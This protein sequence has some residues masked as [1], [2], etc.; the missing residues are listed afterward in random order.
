MG[1]VGRRRRAAAAAGSALL[2]VAACSAPADDPAGHGS[3]TTTSATTAPPSTTPTTTPTGESATRTSAIPPPSP[4]TTTSSTATADALGGYGVSAGHPAAVAVGMGVLERGGNA[5]DAAV[6]VAFAVSVAEPFG[7]GLGGGGAAVLV[8]P[9]VPAEAYTYRETVALDGEIPASGTGIPGY[10]AGLAQL[11]A[12]HGSLDWAVLVEPAVVLAEDG[13]PV[14]E[15][16]ADELRTPA[17]RAAVADVAA[18]HHDDGS[19][20]RAGDPLRQP[21]LA[22]T[23]RILAAD[24]PQAFYG[25]ALT[26]D[27][28]EVDGLDRESLAAYRVQVGPPVRG[29]VGPVDL[30]TA[31]PPLVGATLVQQLQVAEAAGISDLAPGSA[32]SVDLL[33]RAWRVADES[34]GTVL[35]DPGFVDVPVAELTD[36][37]A[38][39]VLAAELADGSGPLAVAMA[40]PVR[41]GTTTQVSVV[42]AD[43]LAVSMTNTILSFWGSGEQVGG[44]FVNDTLR[45]FDVGR[46]AANDAAPGK[47]PVSWTAPS[48]AVDAQGRPVLVIGS[49]GG[50]LIPNILAG[51]LARH[52]LQGQGL[53]A[54]VLAP[55]WHLEG[56]RLAVEGLPSGVRE[57]L[58]ALGYA[59]DR[60][61]DSARLFGSVHAL[62][63]DPET[64]AVSGVADPRRGGAFEVSTP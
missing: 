22:E 55:R 41:P 20:L 39:A 43:G 21:E 47:R 35:G 1:R 62:A 42:D 10:V 37:A 32:E 18:F 50:R 54:A 29:R 60:V 9:G 45:R 12:D 11:H 4:S 44:Y 53:E 48:I 19:L 63:V 51:V 31:P 25:G 61:P 28:A 2:L 5:V 8:G 16:L 15:F 46:T 23:L 33:S 59:V 34:I 57:E 40:Y 30:L 38:N 24:G 52:L 26:A 3:E 14:S 6:A 7:S 27:L 64:G 17:G 56:E 36:P 13:V 49:P 58:G